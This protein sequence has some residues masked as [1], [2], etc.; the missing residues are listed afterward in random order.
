MNIDIKSNIEGKILS[1]AKGGRQIW[2]CQNYFDLHVV[3]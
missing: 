3:C 1:V 2:A